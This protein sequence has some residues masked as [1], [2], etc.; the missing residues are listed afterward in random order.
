MLEAIMPRASYEK[1]RDNEVVDLDLSL[2]RWDN[3]KLK[4]FFLSILP[5]NNSIK[6]L[7]LRHGALNDDHFAIMLEGIRKRNIKLDRLNLDHNKFTGESY[8]NFLQLIESGL[9]GAIYFY[10]YNNVFTD[11]QKNNLQSV[12]ESDHLNVRL[13][14]V[15]ALDRPA[16]PSF[17]Q[18]ERIIALN[19]KLEERK[20]FS[21]HTEN[22]PP[23]FT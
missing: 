17:F 9:V 2:V 16:S 19:Q 3:E 18:D 13:S 6:K 4:D 10:D 12:S 8:D 11:E 23:K 22:D 14:F 1:I 15:N 21:N 5:A 20:D 7:D